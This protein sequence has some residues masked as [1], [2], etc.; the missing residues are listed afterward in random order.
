MKEF[1]K[2]N[3]YELPLVIAFVVSMFYKPMFCFIILGSWVIITSFNYWRF[4]LNI[5]KNGIEG[6]GKI[7]SYESDYKGYKTPIVEFTSKSGTHVR[8]K[9]HFHVST[10]FS[11]LLTHKN[12][13]DT[14]ID[15]LY[16]PN[17][18]EK[19]VIDEE[20]NFYRL[21]LIFAM[22]G[23]LLFFTIGICGILGIIDI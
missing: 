15:I 1:L 19:F 4:L 17:S 3:K 10:D 5:E 8:K 12:T 7:L 18:P 21:S 9:P 14:T 11:K 23:G 22:F 6:V 16:D 2:K 20:E 13:I